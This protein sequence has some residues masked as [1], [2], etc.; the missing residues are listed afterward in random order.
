[1][2]DVG[3]LK[4]GTVLGGCRIVKLIGSG[5][6]G[7]VYLAEHQ[8]L[9]K[10][11]AIKTARSSL[12]DQDEIRRRFLKE[13]RL[14]A[15]V[16]HPNVI[17]IHDIGE[18]NGLLYI[19]MQF[20]QGQ[21]LSQLM[22]SS[23]TPLGWRLVLGWIR[24]ATL[25]LEAVHAQGLIHRDIK[26]HNLMLTTTGRVLVMDFGLVREEDPSLSITN[27][28]VGS[29]AYMSPEMCRNDPVDV[30]TDIY[31][32]GATAYTL[33]AGTH[34]FH[35]SG[36]HSM[37]VKLAQNTVVDRLD[38]VRP[39]IPKEV[40]DLIARAM[41]PLR[42]NRTA[43]T[44]AL[45][46][47]IDQLLGRHFPDAANAPAGAVTIRVPSVGRGSESNPRVVVDPRQA[48]SRRA[49]TSMTAEETSDPSVC[50]TQHV[51]GQ[52]RPQP[53]SRRN[54]LLALLASV[55][56]MGGLISILLAGMWLNTR[57][58]QEA[59]TVAK[60]SGK[61][62]VSQTGPK[63]R[64]VK[65][66][67][68]A[69]SRH[70]SVPAPRI[71]GSQP[72]PG[73]KTTGDKGPPPEIPHEPELAPKLPVE[74]P[75]ETPLETLP[76]PEE[77]VLPQDPPPAVQEKPEPKAQPEMKGEIELVNALV[78]V[79]PKVVP[80][81][82][83]DVPEKP[84]MPEGPKPEIPAV[85]TYAPPSEAKAGEAWQSQE[86]A[87]DFSWCPAGKFQM[88]SPPEERERDAGEV[89]VEVTIAQGF[90]MGRTEVTQGQWVGLLEKKPWA[91]S[92]Y[93][94]DGPNYPAVEVG[95]SGDDPNAEDFCQKLTA[96][97]RKG[98]LSAEWA[99]R[100]PTDAEW[101]YACRAGTTTPYSFDPKDHLADYG[102]FIKNAMDQ[103]EKYAHLVRQMPPNPWGLHDMHG[104]VWEWCAHRQDK[105]NGDL[106]VIRGGSWDYAANYCRSANRGARSKTSTH[107]NV[108][109]RLVLGRVS[110][111]G[112][113]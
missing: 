81:E 26:P 54:E 112:A 101:E 89:Q 57:K 47:E 97:A 111:D 28:A 33:L 27:A 29:P 96:L 113:P 78:V 30:Q 8:M 103:Q 38:T 91:G 56:L 10:F 65:P 64:D 63:M 92:T 67:G 110:A 90:W 68:G 2:T 84:P 76:M 45:I 88:G 51:L 39:D 7:E 62:R 59:A 52:Q 43:D 21:D 40:A 36:L 19:V 49:A 72:V 15:R 14:A 34:P 109:F 104:N 53:K 108:G 9:Q 82:K 98:G 60:N 17:T 5:G 4:P 102:W 80:P 32:M 94:K 99:Y 16:D 3:E 50:N 46:H 74:T 75:P 93:V 1:M 61:S 105:D 106:R 71:E 20:I 69:G 35:D 87:I 55:A 44:H 6:M 79:T 77:K 13:A 37:I 66:T 22:R 48:S 83:V 58:P 42:E 41:A 12:R 95:H 70:T 107:D 11:V 31:S 24:E 18:S 85:K 73:G 86:L 25:G 100:L 23:P